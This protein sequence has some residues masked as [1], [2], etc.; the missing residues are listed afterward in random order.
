MLKRE[1][2]AAAADAEVSDTIT[3]IEEF[4]LSGEDVNANM[5]RMEDK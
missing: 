4:M 5:T 3:E 1:E 2:E